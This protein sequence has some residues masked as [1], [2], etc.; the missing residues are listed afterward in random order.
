MARSLLLLLATATGAAAASQGFVTLNNG[1][2]MPQLA[3][4]TWQYSNATAGDSIAKAWKAGFTHF[5]TA[6]SYANQLGCGKEIASL[7]ASGVKRSDIFVTT[8][9]LPCSSTTNMTAEACEAQTQ[10][11]LQ[12][13]LKRLGLDYVDLILLHGPSTRGTGSTDMCNAKACGADQGSWSA[14]ETMY[15]NK[16]VNRRGH[17]ISR[18]TRYV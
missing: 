9:T 12:K 14:L 18:P 16:Q 2:R 4:G 15:A 13:D 1:V 11:D 17:C 8:K 7:L 10:S 3:A 5:D 6:E